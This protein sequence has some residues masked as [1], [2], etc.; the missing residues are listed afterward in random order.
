MSEETKIRVHAPT[1]LLVEHGDT[2][3]A[4]SGDADRIHGVKFDLPLTGEG[5]KQMQRAAEIIADFEVASFE[6]SPMI[7]SKQSAEIIGREIGKKPVA[8]EALLPWDSGFAS[9]MTHGAAKDLIEFYVKNPEKVIRDGQAYA[10]WWDKF[11]KDMLATLKLAE[12]TPG[13]VHVR[14]VHSSEVTAA[15]AIIKGDPAQVM[16][17]R[18]PASGQVAALEKRGGRWRFIPKYA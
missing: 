3:F 17:Q 1:V 15:P 7:R 12:K 18:L 6:H 14:A 8:N 11:Q 9:G 10:E 4:G 5:R 13:Q 16:K 2:E